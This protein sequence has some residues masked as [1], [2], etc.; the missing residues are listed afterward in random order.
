MSFSTLYTSLNRINPKGY[1]LTCPAVQFTSTSVKNQCFLV[2]VIFFTCLILSFFK[3][4]Q[5]AES[6][7]N[8]LWEEWRGL[9]SKNKYNKIPHTI[10]AALDLLSEKYIPHQGNKFGSRSNFC[11]GSDSACCLEI[12]QQCNNAASSCSGG[13]Q[14]K[15]FFFLRQSVLTHFIHKI[16]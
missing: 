14:L 13:K 5:C 7:N 2:S 6:R 4:P 8:F 15:N 10:L 3:E 1:E 12:L 11:Y 9:Q 16:K